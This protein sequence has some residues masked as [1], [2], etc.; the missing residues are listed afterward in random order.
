M[1]HTIENEYL[2]AE[3][4]ELGATLTR[5]ID[6][7]SGIDIVL[8]FDSDEEYF[9]NASSNLGAT[10]GR[11]ANRL[12]KAGFTL[13]GR[14]Y[15][16]KA[17]DGSNNLHG[18]GING[19]AFRMWETVKVTPEEIVLTYFSKDGEEGFPGNLKVILSYALKNNSLV[20]TFSG[21]SDA[22]TIFNLT[23][24]SYF[25]LGGDDILNHRLRITSSRYAPTDENAL[26][27]D[28]VLDC[29]GT[30]YDFSSEKR[31]GENLAKLSKGIDNNYV[32]ED[33]N[34]KLLAQLSFDQLQLNVYSDLPDMHLYTAYYLDTPDGKNERGYGRY[35]GVALEAQFF[36]N[37]INYGDKYLSPVLKKGEKIQH[38]ITFEVLNKE[39]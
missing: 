10:I 12:A 7:K 37:G 39:V 20:C 30:A 19:F 34:D 4:S 26:T 5:L 33:L 27:L 35:D 24:H 25:N 13:N 18:G 6:K 1:R 8:G 32:W 17:N 23:N 31:I 29:K 15:Q 16:L 28:E 36:P 2:K 3:I 38:Y 9:A 11:N 14:Q 21:E 22:D